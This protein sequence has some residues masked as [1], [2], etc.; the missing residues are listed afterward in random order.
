[1]DANKE[2]W[3]R[4]LIKVVLII[5]AFILFGVSKDNLG[6]EPWAGIGMLI[7]VGLLYGIWTYKPK[8]RE[9]ELD[10]TDPR[11]KA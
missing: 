2:K 8:L 3:I 5:P 4:R 6:K 9:G 11:S 10:K 1:M 7:G